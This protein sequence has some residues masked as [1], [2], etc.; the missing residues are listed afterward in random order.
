MYAVQIDRHGGPDVLNYI[1]VPIPVPGPGQVL[2][3]MKAAAL[4]HLDIWV[5]RGFPGIPLPIIPGSDG[6]GVV[7]EVGSG[8]SDYKPGDAVILQPVSYCGHC[9]FCRQER[10]NFCDNFGIFGE[11]RDGTN[12]E[13]MTVAEKYL[14]PKPAWLN[15][16]EAAAFPL[17]TM[18]AYTMLIKRANL[19]TD[20]SVFIWGA[21]SGVGHMAVQIAKWKGCYVIATA[22]SKNKLKQAQKLGADLVVDHYAENII[23]AVRSGS[24]RKSIDVI[25]EHVGQATWDISTKLLAKGGRI[26]TCGA[27]TGAQAKIDLRHIF[28]KQQS[29]IGSTM[30]DVAGFDEMLDLVNNQQL[31]PILDRTFPLSEIAAA[32]ACLERGEHFGKIAIK[33]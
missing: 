7:A 17:V 8:V 19:Q 13:F 14:R 20:E 12:C 6:S 1:E 3:E 24:G 27:T 32:Q 29:I 9:R 11:T 15:F 33:I 31:K 16:T 5:R 4:N 21:G 28:Y 10:E 25:F 18:T 2:L 26:V 23:E 30:G 22:G